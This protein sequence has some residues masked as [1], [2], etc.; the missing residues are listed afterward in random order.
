M[1]AI[2]LTTLDVASLKALY[3]KNLALL[4]EKLLS[5]ADWYE[6]SD[7]RHFVTQLEILLDKKMHPIDSAYIT[8]EY[9]KTIT[10]SL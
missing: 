1:D 9:V 6:T 7:L 4:N 10:K 3:H 5:G 2:D 8:D